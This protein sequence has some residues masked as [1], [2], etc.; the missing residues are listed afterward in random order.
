MAVSDSFRDFVIEQLEQT[1]RDIRTRRMFGGVGIYAGEVFFAV[2]DNDTL[3]F[4]VDDQTRPTFVKRK[5]KP[6]Q[7][8]GPDGGTIGYY[9][10]PI[11]V[12]EDADALRIWVGDALAVAARAQPRRRRHPAR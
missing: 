2:I 5:M 12:L 1:H 10:V 9:Q 6:F 4:K 8:Y 11:G 3:Y 7:P